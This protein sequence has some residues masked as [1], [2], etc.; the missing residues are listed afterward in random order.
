MESKIR[1]GYDLLLVLR[2][3]ASAALTA[4]TLSAKI[5]IDRITNS[6]RDVL[7]GKYGQR[8][9][10]VVIQLVAGFAPGADNVYVLEFNTYDANGAN[11]VTHQ[12]KAIVAADVG[13]TIVLS[14]D[15]D[16]LAEFDADASQFAVNLNVT[17][18]T[19]S[20]TFWAIVAPIG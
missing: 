1:H 8:K 11:P 4:D 6:A 5:G 16:S 15:C 19:P 12:T 20:A 10:D 17:G 2:A 18:T 14:F 13:K 9:F 3:P 7:D